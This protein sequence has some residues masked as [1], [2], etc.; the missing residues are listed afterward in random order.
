MEWTVSNGFGPYMVSSLRGVPYLLCDDS[1]IS[2]PFGLFEVSFVILKPIKHSFLSRH[3]SIQRPDSQLAP[4][5][6]WYSGARVRADSNDDCPQLE[7]A[8][9]ARPSSCG[10]SASSARLCRFLIP[11]S[12]SDGSAIWN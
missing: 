5:L 10:P 8:T 9:A 6:E 7:Q 2:N 3:L 11:V 1:V 4:V 12:D